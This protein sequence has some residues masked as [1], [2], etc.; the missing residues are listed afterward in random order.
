MDSTAA[1][2]CIDNG[3]EAFV[4]DMKEDSNISKAAFGQASG[5]HIVIE[6]GK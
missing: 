5:T 4:F 6:R 2:M 3:I 1:S